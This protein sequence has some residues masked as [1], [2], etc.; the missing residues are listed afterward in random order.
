MESRFRYRFFNPIKIIQGAD[1]RHGKDV[2]AVGC[3]T[4]FFTVPLARFLGDKGSLTS[5]DILPESVEKV[6]KKIQD[7][8]LRN[9]RVFKGDALTTQIDSE[10]MDVIILFGV[11]PAPMLPMTKLLPE[12]RRIL[13]PGG[14]ISVWPPIGVH[15]SILK[16]Q[17][18]TFS[19]K[20]K[21]VLTYKRI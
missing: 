1:I 10:S 16:S 6:T 9:V 12:M 2:L 8:N 21:N 18:F 3:G 14:R 13:K 20:R 19:G 17:L 11:I 15:K 4:G 5:I 7:A